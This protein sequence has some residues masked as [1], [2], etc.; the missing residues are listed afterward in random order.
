[1]S[2]EKIRSWLKNKKIGVL[3]GGR[4]AERP[5]SLL[6]G[7]AVLKALRGSG[8]KAIGIDAKGDLAS[9][10]RQNRIDFAYIA[11]HGP[12]GEDGTVQGM[13][14]I[15]GIPYSGC[16]VLSSALSMNKI[17]SK[18]VFDSCGI[19]TPRWTLVTKEGLDKK[20][21]IFPCFVKPATQGSA[22]GVSCV[23]ERKDFRASAIKAL[24]FDKQI[25]VEEFIRGKE[26]TVA[27]LGDKALPVIEIVP[28][29]KFYDYESK[30]RPGFSR[31]LIP[32]RLPER[33][34]RESQELALNVFK[35]LDC[36]AV[37]RIDIIIDK[38]N[39]PWVLEANTVPG[40]TQTSLLP[41]AAAAAGLGFVDLIL[42]IIRHSVQVN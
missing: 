39:K 30:Y 23:T 36:K 16:G 1:M 18:R 42:E 26:I 32:A 10:L 27:V 7:K 41:D 12:W 19:P 29:N 17:F 28:V 2:I 3:Y 33:V 15:M 37:A 22:I 6:S 20:I 8:F 5:I 25:L 4:S 31:H 38:K 35:A 21:P 11:L 13:L 34:A 24:K 9:L 14:E 40:M